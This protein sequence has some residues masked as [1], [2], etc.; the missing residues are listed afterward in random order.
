M[1][2]GSSYVKAEGT[3]MGVEVDQVSW[4][5]RTTY[6]RDQGLGDDMAHRRNQVLPVGL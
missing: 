2:T 1:T 3:E 5:E 4:A 6:V